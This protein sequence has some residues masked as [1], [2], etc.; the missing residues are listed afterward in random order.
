MSFCPDTF[1][2]IDPEERDVVVFD[3]PATARLPGELVVGADITVHL[4]HGD[5]PDPQAMLDGQPSVIEGRYVQQAIVGRADGSTYEI[6]CLAHL[7]GG[8]EDRRILTGMVV[9]CRRKG[10]AP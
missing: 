3:Y 6:R 7:S 5:D 1:A 10:L 9:P 8:G 2:P 4:L